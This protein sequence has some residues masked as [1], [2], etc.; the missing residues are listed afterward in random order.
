MDTYT[1]T[2]PSIEWGRGSGFNFGRIK[3]YPNVRIERSNYPDGW[4]YLLSDEFQTYLKVDN[5]RF[6]TME[7]LNA[8]VL[9]HVANIRSM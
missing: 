1:K 5:R 9:E 6:K 8:A 7:E 3:E 4:G 2:Q